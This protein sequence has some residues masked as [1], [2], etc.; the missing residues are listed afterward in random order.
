MANDMSKPI[1]YLT[2]D[3]GPKGGEALQGESPVYSISHADKLFEILSENEGNMQYSNF[4]LMGHDKT[5]ITKEYS[6]H[7]PQKPVKPPLRRIA[8]NKN[9]GNKL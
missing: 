3:F 2:Y 8:P 4:K 6:K 9:K 7:F 5:K 1:G